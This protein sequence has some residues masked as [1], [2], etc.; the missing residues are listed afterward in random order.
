MLRLQQFRRTDL[1]FIKIDFTNLKFYIFKGEIA[2]GFPL[3]GKDL[4]VDPGSY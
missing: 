3:K 1:K 2:L 4:I